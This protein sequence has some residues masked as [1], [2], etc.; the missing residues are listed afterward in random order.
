MMSTAIQLSDI[1]ITE[2]LQRRPKRLA[3]IQKELEALR[4]INRYI[5]QGSAAPVSELCDYVATMCQAGSAGVSVLRT[6]GEKECLSWEV[7]VGKAASMVG[8][9]APRNDCPCGV[10]LKHKAPQLFDRPAR[11]FRWM[12]SFGVPVVESLVI[13]LYRSNVKPIGTMWIMAHDEER[14]FDKEDVRVL[15]ELSSYVLTAITRREGAVA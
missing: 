15:R 2:Q 12:E 10:S 5:A 11:Y 6:I 13:P 1:L 4:N 14:K 3:N 9:N 8:G 7:V